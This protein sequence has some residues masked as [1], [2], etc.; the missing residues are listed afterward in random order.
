M[1]PRV[2]FAHDFAEAYG[3][4][5][6]LFAEAAAEFPDG[7][8]YAL[9]GR[10][11][12][13]ARMGVADRF[14]SL[15]PAHPA[16]LR[17]YRWLAPAYPLYAALRK[18]P[19]ADLLITSSYAY[20][21]G[22]RTENDA[23]QLCYCHSPLRHAWSQVDAY[24]S[25]LPGSP[26]SRRAYPAF[27]AA[28]RAAD[29]RASRR[30]TRYLTQSRFTAEQIERFYDKAAHVVPPPVD[31]ELF[32]PGEGGPGDHFLFCGRL[33]EAYKRPSL[34]VEAF[35]RM[36][37]LKLRV[38]GAGPALPALRAAAG[39]NIEFLGHLDDARLVHEMQH[40]QAAVFPSVDDFGLI[41]VEVAACGRPVL[42]YGRGGALAT[43][44]EGVSGTFFHEQS[45]DAIVAA[46][47]AY[48]PAAWD[49][50]AIRAH[51]M[52]WDRRKFRAAIRRHA[53]ELLAGA[54]A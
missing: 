43:V 13:A 42:A 9:L 30:V 51:A 19:A 32:T 34:V 31:T 54:G 7:P 18:L 8:L 10:T 38:A 5:E 2:V 37:D 15:L 46:V 17:H 25:R 16:F 45:A 21:H 24:G 33:V 28:M 40:C 41:P 11:E 22:M 39:P 35:N 26:V 52:G 6:R 48:D 1:S 3:G 23:P 27:A 47:R 20:V 50:E 4:A 49:P 53:D 44:R 36:P 29:R 14:H 12:V